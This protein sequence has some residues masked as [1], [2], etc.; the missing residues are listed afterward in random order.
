MDKVKVDTFI[1]ANRECFSEEDIPMIR[2]RMET[3]EDCKWQ[4]LSTLNFKHPQ[5][6]LMLS[7]FGG[8]IGVD[9]LYIGDY[10]LGV[11]K[12][13]TCGG[14]L[15]WAF[16]DQFLIRKATKDNNRDMLMSILDL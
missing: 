1:L 11:F 10:L 2:M 12:T 9:R 3:A 7:I 8:P 16:V 14:I 5:T 15:I 6:A 4:A 13:I